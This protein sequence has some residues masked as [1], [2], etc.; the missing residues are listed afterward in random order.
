M[1]KWEQVW[2]QELPQREISRRIK[3]QFDTFRNHFQ[4][5]ESF[6]AKVFEFIDR[7]WGNS[8]L[9]D[10]K[11]RYKVYH[12]NVPPDMMGA[13]A[14][15]EGGNLLC[16]NA[17]LLNQ[18]FLTEKYYYVGGIQM[19]DTFSVLMHALL[20]EYVHVFLYYARRYKVYDWRDSHGPEFMKRVKAWY[21]HTDYQ[22]SLIPGF[23]ENRMMRSVQEGDKVKVFVDKDSHVIGV[24]VKRNNN[25]INVKGNLYP[26]H[27]GVHDTRKING[28]TTHIGRVMAII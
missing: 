28:V 17:E 13:A 8:I 3:E 20:H 18:L 2:H 23:Q 9:A 27:P 5:T 15:V 12:S 1:E 4:L 26:S 25:E 10:V 19:C 21:G 22:H 14:W 16:V 7:V 24:V 6:I 11:M